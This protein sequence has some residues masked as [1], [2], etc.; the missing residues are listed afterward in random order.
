MTILNRQTR[1]E[2]LSSA[3]KLAGAALLS[4]GVLFGSGPAAAARYDPKLSVQN[5]IWIQRLEVEKKTLAEGLDEV[6]SSFHD[7][8]YPRV[9]L[10]TGFFTPE[11]RDKTLALLDKYKMVPETFF[12]NSTMHEAAAAEKSVNDALELAQLLKPH[13]TR[14]IIV[15]PIPKPNNVPKTDEELNTQARYVAQLADELN[16]LGMKLALHHHT[17]ELI[18]N[19]REW[20]HLMQH[21]NPDRVYCCVDVHWAYRGGQNPMTFLRAAGDRLLVL[22]LRNSKEGIWMEDFGPGDVD[23]TQ[24]ANYLRAIKFAGYLVVEL[25]YEPGMQPTRP[26]TE[27]LRLSRL[28][29][30]KVFGPPA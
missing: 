3:S 8:G 26:L 10:G 19:Q 2:M 22:H 30:E 23:Y 21:T 29:T 1:R 28:Y 5:Y 6:L 11:L 7:A 13:G 4:R 14:V 18:N 27:D 15:N 24:V 17:P 25:A 20:R 16:K 12:P 9:E